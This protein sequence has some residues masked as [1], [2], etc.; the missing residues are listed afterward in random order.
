MPHTREPQYQAVLELRAKYG[1]TRLGLSS[2]ISWYED[3][4]RLAFSFSRYKFVSKML[5]GS[6][7]VLE[8]GCGDG[9]FSR[10]V[11]QETGTLTAIDFD[12]VFIEDALDRAHPEWEIDFRPHDMLSGPVSGQ[13]FDAAYTLDVLEHIPMEDENQFLENVV[14]SLKAHGTLIVGM[15][16]LNSQTYAS[17]RSREGHVN[18][19][20][21]PDLEALLEKY[22]EYVFM[23]SMNDEVVHTGYHPMAQ[24]LLALCCAP[25]SLSGSAG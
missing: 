25:K 14:R 3:P 19:K 4:K 21:A 22:F 17:P 2:D 12:Q 13:P 11:L 24:Y 15:P 16:S 7:R 23:F 20:H 1:A 10:V 5:S 18:C 9:F 8:I 6:E